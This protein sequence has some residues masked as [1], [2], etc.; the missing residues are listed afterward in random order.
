MK[1]RILLALPLLVFLPSY[2]MAGVC[3]GVSFTDPT[4]GDADATTFCAACITGDAM[5]DEVIERINSAISVGGGTV[6]LPTCDTT[7]TTGYMAPS[8]LPSNVSIS[9]I[10]QGS[11]SSIFRKET[12][13]TYRIFYFAFPVGDVSPNTSYVRISGVGFYGAQL[14]GSGA[15]IYISNADDFRVDHCI[16]YDSRWN[17]PISFKAVTKGLMDSNSFYQ[18]YGGEVGDPDRFGLDFGQNQ[19]PPLPSCSDIDA[20]PCVTEAC[21]TCET[22][23]LAWLDDTATN[24]GVGLELYNDWMP[25]TENKVYVENN[26]IKWS[27][28]SMLRSNWS[29]RMSYVFRYNTVDMDPDYGNRW[30]SIKPGSGGLEIYN[31]DMRCYDWGDTDDCPSNP[32]DFGNV[33][34]GG[35]IYRNN[36]HN[37]KASGI[38]LIEGKYCYASY[39]CYP[40]PAFFDEL[41][42]WGNTYTDNSFCDTN[43]CEDDDNFWGWEESDPA[44]VEITENPTYSSQDTGR[45]YTMAPKTGHRIY[46]GNP[47]APV[48]SYTC[49]HPKAELTGSCDTTKFGQSGYNVNPSPIRVIGC[50]LSGGSNIK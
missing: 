36:W 40:I 49:P 4:C 25:G 5:H 13:G 22:A 7:L 18:L 14:S 11:A 21:T 39:A 15:A 24:N 20:I 23:H 10:G 16:W 9:I 46:S 27:G 41:Y 8:S 45:F 29:N 44:N 32:M 48:N 34:S 2:V 37:T 19:Q 3:D 30:L 42:V 38:I 6:C 1:N 35:L 33:L 26:Y 47:S 12:P 31:N 17:S 28:S 43:P 50:V